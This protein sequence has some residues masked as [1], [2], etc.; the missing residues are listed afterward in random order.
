MSRKK[1]GGTSPYHLHCADARELAAV[2]NYLGLPATPFITTTITSPPY[3]TLKDY[4]SA[5]QVGWR[6]AHDDYLT[7]C[8]KV[9]EQVH[10]STVPSGSL[11]LI[12]DT[13]TTR[14][15]KDVFSLQLLPFQL[16]EVAETVGWTLRDVII[17]HKDRTVPWAAPGRLR[18]AFE[19]VLFFVKGPKFKYYPKRLAEPISDSKWW[20]RFPE[21]YSPHGITPSNV[22]II[23]IPKQ[24]AWGQESVRHACPLPPDLVDRLL[25]LSTDPGDVVFDTFA[26]TG[27]VLACAATLGREP[28]GLETSEDL[29]TSF[30]LP[31]KEEQLRKSATPVD[32][33][34]TTI[35]K[36][37][38]LKYARVVYERARGVDAFD[39]NPVRCAVVQSTA[40]LRAPQ[41]VLGT[42]TYVV[43]GRLTATRR[44]AMLS[45]LRNAASG[46]PASKFGVHLEID[47]ATTV[48]DP[49]RKLWRYPNGRFW[50]HDGK[51]NVSSQLDNEPRTKRLTILSNLRVSENREG[52]ELRD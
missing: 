30:V 10:A 1:S 15:P 33:T 12:L 32:P 19:Y 3:G 38:A 47:V 52:V 43:S 49:E 51:T 50:R 17:W 31:R 8:G 27:T 2:F 18:N 21:R 24:G 39:H 45:A 28:L 7:D 11:W 4:G 25:A 16:A 37:R 5:R 46:R 34:G 26:G 41:P 22:W 44:A 9:L 42:V 40:R 23:P 35:L 6:Q 48:P 13:V 29:V 20:V 36:L 14:G